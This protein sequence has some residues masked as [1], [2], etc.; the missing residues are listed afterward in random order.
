V[1]EAFASDLDAAVGYA[2]EHGEE[3]AS[4]SA[5]YGGAPGGHTLEAEEMIRGV[6]T[7]L[8]DSQ[9]GVPEMQGSSEA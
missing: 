4:S 3:P 9:Q 6:M 7:Q 5:V 1:V 2:R 8:M